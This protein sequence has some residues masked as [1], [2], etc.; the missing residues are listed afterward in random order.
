MNLS[1]EVKRKL[2]SAIE[3]ELQR[4]LDLAVEDHFWWD[5]D[6]A[7]LVKHMRRHVP[8]DEASDEDIALIAKAIADDEYEAID[9]DCSVLVNFPKNVDDLEPAGPLDDHLRAVRAT[10]AVQR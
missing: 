8:S 3:Q 6:E 5:V 2:T 1:D 7:D 4:Q 10:R 9:V